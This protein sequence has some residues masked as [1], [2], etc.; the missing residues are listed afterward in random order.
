MQPLGKQPGSGR[1]QDN[2][3]CKSNKIPQGLPS[4]TGLVACKN[5][6]AVQC[7]CCK[8][9]TDGSNEYGSSIMVSHGFLKKNSQD[10]IHTGSCKSHDLR[11]HVSAFDSG[12]YCS[13]EEC[14]GYGFIL[15]SR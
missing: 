10:K 13:V 9:P 5:P 7:E 4:I 12:K 15:I 6:V 2:A 1:I 3:S 14:H 8:S 11:T